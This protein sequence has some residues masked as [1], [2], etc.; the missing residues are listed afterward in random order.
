MR[1]VAAV[2]FLSGCLAAAQTPADDPP[3]LDVQASIDEMEEAL[4]AYRES[5]GSEEL[6]ASRMKQLEDENKSLKGEV[7]SLS[8]KLT[9]CESMVEE[10]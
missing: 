4:N 6:V 10:D 7:A 8:Q 1:H 3:A 9:L 5:V 2:L